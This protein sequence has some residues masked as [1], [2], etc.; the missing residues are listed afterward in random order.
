MKITPTPAARPSRLSA[1]LAIASLLVAAPL[2]A[3]PAT[4]DIEVHAQPSD[5]APVIGSFPASRSPSPLTLP[6]PPP[7]GW[8]A[9]EVPGPHSVYVANKDVLKNYDIR[10]G[11]EYRVS[12]S[13][14][15]AV[16]GSADAADKTGLVGL[17]GQFTEYTLDRALVGYIRNRPATAATADAAS[18]VVTVVSSD[19]TDIAAPAPVAPF[20]TTLTLG[21]GAQL[22]PLQ[23]PVPG[24]A[25]ASASALPPAAAPTTTPPPPPSPDEVA[26]NAVAPLPPLLTGNGS[27][28]PASTPPP[29]AAPV[30]AAA[31]PAEPFVPAP[32]G[33]AADTSATGLPRMILGTFASSKQFFR[34]SRPYPFQL[35][36][37]T[38]ARYAYVDTSRLLLTEKLE[39]FLG[40]KVVVYGTIRPAPDSKD[41]VIAAET[42]KLQ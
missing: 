11:A 19:P 39:S 14:S 28:F 40:R 38:G 8:S 6:T 9:V 13:E 25:A 4:G 27:A 35:N 10:P 30:A 3:L 29:V 7:Q 37:G 20:D 17:K 1:L 23:T 34:P 12:P 33:R 16:L 32:A 31:A 21:S 36:D 26:A 42:L 5:T 18:P 15:A 41:I 22:T 2:P 24:D